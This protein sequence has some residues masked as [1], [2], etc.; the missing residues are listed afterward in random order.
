MTETTT[1]TNGTSTSNT[2]KDKG[3]QVKSKR[4]LPPL[5][6]FGSAADMK[7]VQYTALVSDVPTDFSNLENNELFSLN[8]DGSFPMMRV[9]RSKATSL[10]DGKGYPCGSGRCYR[11]S[12]SA[13]PTV[14][15]KNMQTGKE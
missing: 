5:T 6:T 12:L 3:K 9:S 14:E 13:H 1:Y 8:Q 15:P 2:A 7:K 10:H 11:I 4:N